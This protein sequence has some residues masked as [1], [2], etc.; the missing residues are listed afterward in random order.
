M[1]P[2][3]FRLEVG[4][5]VHTHLSQRYCN[6]SSLKGTI[7]VTVTSID[8]RR[9]TYRGISSKFQKE[10]CL[11]FGGVVRKVGGSKKVSK[12]SLTRLMEHFNQ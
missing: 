2:T 12:E 1:K 5:K 3:P 11:P 4:M 8:P 6:D 9:L 7:V 10:L